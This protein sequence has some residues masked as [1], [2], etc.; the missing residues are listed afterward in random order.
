MRPIRSRNVKRSRSDCGA[1][2]SPGDSSSAMPVKCGAN[3]SSVNVRT[4][5]RG[6]WITRRRAETDLSTTK[7]FMSQ[8][9]MHGSCSSRRLCRS[10]FSGR[11]ARPSAAA[12]RT[13]PSKLAPLRDRP[14]RR[15]SEGRSVSRPRLTATIARQASPHSVASVCR[16][17]G[18]WRRRPSRRV[19]PAGTGSCCI[20]SLIAR[21]P[22]RP[23]GVPAPI[24]PACGARRRGSPARAC[25][26]SARRARPARHR[27]AHRGPA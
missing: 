21:P 10:S 8:C 15:R 4:P 6:S 24:R 22:A 12:T 9:R 20:A 18:R 3:S 26:P 16:I 13:R 19:T 27:R 11:L 17:T 2:P 23:P 25:R 1:K 14:K 7:W 5:T